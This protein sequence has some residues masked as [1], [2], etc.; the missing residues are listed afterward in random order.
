MHIL[1]SRISICYKKVVK[2]FLKKWQV[3]QSLEAALEPEMLAKLHHDYDSHD[4]SQYRP[5]SIDF[6][7]RQAVL[8]Q[9]QT[10][11]EAI[12]NVASQAKEP[13]RSA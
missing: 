6:P 9:I 11:E 5:K 2:L 10:E 7:S 8:K 13:R 12:N 1:A 4:G 3:V